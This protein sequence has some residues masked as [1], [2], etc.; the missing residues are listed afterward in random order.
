MDELELLPESRI[1]QVFCGS[2]VGSQFSEKV[3]ICEKLCEAKAFAAGRV[4]CCAREGCQ[5]GLDD[6][7]EFR[8]LVPNLLHPEPPSAL[9][10]EQGYPP[11]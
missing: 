6:G 11:V 9:S 3:R 1:C 2:W 10:S 8:V 4:M 5:E 7:F